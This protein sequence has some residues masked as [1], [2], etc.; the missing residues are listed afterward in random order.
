MWREGGSSIVG[1][2][3]LGKNSAVENNDIADEA[4]TM[5]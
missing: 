3:R 1:R 5:V 4:G 2:N